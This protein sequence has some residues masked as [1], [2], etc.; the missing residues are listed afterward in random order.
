VGIPDGDSGSA[1]RG[2]IPSFKRFQPIPFVR[3]WY[4][5]RMKAVSAPIWLCCASCCS[6]IHRLLHPALLLLQCPMVDLDP[7]CHSA[8]FSRANSPIPDHYSSPT[9]CRRPA[10]TPGIRGIAFHTLPDAP[11]LLSPPAAN[12][13]APASAR[14]SVDASPAGSPALQ[15]RQQPPPAA[16]R[17]RRRLSIEAYQLLESG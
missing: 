14:V 15:S 16:P 6:A 17:I 1:R 7:P 8:Y 10:T 11:L 12:V 4:S 13:P 5:N 2:M 9:P 3:T